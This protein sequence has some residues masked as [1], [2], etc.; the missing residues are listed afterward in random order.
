MR[1]LALTLTAALVVGGC[2]SESGVVQDALQVGANSPATPSPALSAKAKR[3]TAFAAM[4]DRGALLAF[5]RL[6]QPVRRKAHTY[7]AVQL[8]E[9]HALK[10]ARPGG[11][12]ELP[13][14][15][16]QTLRV[17]YQRHEESLDG[18]WTWIGT[19]LDGMEAVI[20]FGEK[21]VFGRIAQPNT[22]ALR[23]TMSGGR[24][25][26]VETDPSKL[27]DGNLLGDED[28]TGMLL[29]PKTVQATLAGKRAKSA[30]TAAGDKAS[31][32]ETVDVVVGYTNGLVTKYGGVSQAT[33]RLTYLVALSNLAYQNSQITGRV[34]LVHTLQVNYTDTNSNELALQALTGQTCNPTC[35]PSAVPAELVPLRTARDQ[36]GGDL[37]SLVRPFQAPQHQGCGIAW[38]LGG[39]GFTIDNTDAPFGYSIVSDGN[40]DD[41]T[42]GRNYFCREETFAHELGHNMGQQHNTED[43]GGDSGTHSYSYGYREAS[44]TGFYTIMAY[45]LSNSSQF[46]ITHFGNPSVNYS[47][48]PTG[49]A[50]ADNARSLNISMPLVAQFR[51]TVV[52]FVGTVNNDLNGNGTSDLLWFNTAANKFAYWLMN[53]TTLV[54]SGAFTVGANYRVVATPDLDGDGRTDLMWRDVD[55]NTYYYWRSR[56][57]GQFDTGRIAGVAAGWLVERTADLNGDGRHDIIW[58]NSN[59]PGQYALWFMNGVSTIGQTRVFSVPTEYSV[60]GTGDLDGD[61]RA[62]ILWN[63]ASIRQLYAWRSRND[64]GA[65][66]DYLAL[67]GYGTGWEVLETGDINGDGRSDIVWQNIADGSFAHWIMNGATRVSSAAVNIGTSARVVAVG[68]FNGDGRYD[69]VVRNGSVFTLRRSQGTTYEAPAGMTGVG[70]EWQVLP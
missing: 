32:A 56:G 55:T 59:T 54:S 22:E 16:G 6:Q 25:W 53:N 30:P 37:V 43:S 34:R 24:A 63:N 67:G 48:R 10:A 45:R 41:E 60:V 70:V 19:T 29:P 23:L 61:G 65:T 62:D 69:V 15:S 49:T 46:A 31:P 2:T 7:H 64:N 13:T 17:A 8:S 14:P 26:L 21:A 66:W 68:D 52:P 47:G 44:S 40:D 4:P 39:G 18:N 3:T 50:T 11:I 5:E 12:I 20:T 1:K 57:D 33:S 58:R 38:L 42:D 36:Y 51:A 28:D 35:S 27:L 9:A